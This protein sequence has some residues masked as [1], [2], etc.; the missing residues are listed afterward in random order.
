VAYD[1]QNGSFELSLS[2]QQIR[3]IRI[4]TRDPQ[5]LVC[6]VSSNKYVVAIRFRKLDP[7]LKLQPIV[8]HTAFELTLCDF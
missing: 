8:G 1:A 4:E 2:G 3:L 5:E 6:D 7:S